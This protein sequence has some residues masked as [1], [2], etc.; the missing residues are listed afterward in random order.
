[1]TGS[2][3]H[4]RPGSTQTTGALAGIRV[5]EF[6]TVF[7]GPYAGQLLG[8]L[9]ADV[10]KVEERSGDLSRRM[11][12]GPHPELSGTALNLHRNKRSIVLDCKDPHGRDAFLRLAGTADVIITNLRPALLLTV[13]RR[14]DPLSMT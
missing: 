11:G 1:M 7:M 6:A 12:S 14:I 8:D 2:A 10:I 9:G 13:P 3:E 5:I 4:P